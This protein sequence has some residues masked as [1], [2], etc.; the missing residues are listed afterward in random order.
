MADDT[1]RTRGIRLGVCL[2][3]VVVLHALLGRSVAQH[4]AEFGEVASM[5]PRM[6]VAFV[7]DMEVVAPPAVAALPS[8]L[9]A[10]PQA[11]KRAPVMSKAASQ[12]Q[13]QPTEPPQEQPPP[14]T[15]EPESVRQPDKIIAEAAPPPQPQPSAA[16]E[17]APGSLT[18]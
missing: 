10:A 4:M 7:R 5:P 15:P 8:V 3:G 13:A 1:R 18:S 6:D 2:L 14:P 11:A 16:V 17:P 9:A 12:P